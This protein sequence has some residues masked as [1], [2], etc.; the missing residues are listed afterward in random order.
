MTLF[1]AMSRGS[2]HLLRFI[3][4]TEYESVTERGQPPQP[5][6]AEEAL[7]HLHARYFNNSFAAIRASV[8]WNVVQIELD[9]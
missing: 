1:K 4:M 9:R 8:W 2:V 5:N 3:L 6:P 7:L